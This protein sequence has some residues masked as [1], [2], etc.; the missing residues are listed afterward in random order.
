MKVGTA[1]VEIT[2]PLG[3]PMQGYE[4]RTAGA[5]GVHDPLFA[6]V[7]AFEGPDEAAVL[8]VADLLKFDERLQGLIA[9]GVK[10]RLGFDRDRL[11]LIGTHTHSGPA[12]S[13]PSEYERRTAE[14]IA[15]AVEQAWDARREA[16]AAV[17]AAPVS[18]IGRNRRH[19]HEGPVDDDVTMLRIDDLSGAPIANLVN[20]SCHPTTLGPDNL[21]YS[22]D[23]PGV[24]CRILDEAIGGLS[25]F[26]TGAL[27]DVNPG[28][29]SPED[30]MIGIV[31]P[32][33]TFESAERYGQAI[34]TVARGVH[35]R[36]SP[37]PSD[38]VWARAQAVELPRRALPN[39]EEAEA[40]VR[41]AERLVASARPLESIQVP[42]Y[43]RLAEAH[44]RLV[45]DHTSRPD[46]DQPVRI[47]VSA[48]ALGPATHVGIQGELFTEL[49]LEIKRRIGPGRTFI[50]V[51]CDGTVGYIPTADA[52]AE[53]GY[54]PSASQLAPGGGEQLVDA[55]VALA[56][57][58][59]GGVTVA[60]S[61][62][63][64]GSTQF[65]FDTA[66]TLTYRFPTH[67]NL[68][69]MDRAQA[70]RSE[71]FWVVLEPGEAPPLHAH[72]DAEQIFF[73]TEGTAELRIGADALEVHAVH[74]GDLVRISPG[75]YHSV[76]AAGDTRT[77]YLSIDCFLS[78][79]SDEPTWDDHVRALCAENG[80]VFEDV[81]RGRSIKV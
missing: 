38:R 45:L 70:A 53:G 39:A 37:A 44:A 51:L 11:Q 50:A 73:V 32:W 29:Y 26:T 48:L 7:L 34:A 19:P 17:G 14:R 66:D 59:G 15:E 61:P 25:V 24:V 74:V 12:F 75:T 22:A 33:R 16:V 2:P 55:V 13:E 63:A 58:G 57:K 27:G 71:V 52:F 47:R 76:R 18:G 46:R 67:S 20:Y 9:G 77:V 42:Y 30:S 43:A 78:G 49:G 54:E 72:P 62:H 79:R 1:K 8:V 68:L 81:V 28:G 21:L 64:V 5:I 65:V 10:E 80:W 6:R 4:T 31:A 69:V 35:P 41:D 56:A 23:Y 3:M 60:A 36:L 40:A